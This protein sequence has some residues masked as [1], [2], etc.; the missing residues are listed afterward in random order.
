MGGKGRTKSFEEH[1]FNLPPSMK[2]NLTCLRTRSIILLVWGSNLIDW[3]NLITRY[4]ME[5]WKWSLMYLGS[6]LALHGGIGRERFEFC[7][8]LVG[9]AKCTS[10]LEED[11]SWLLP[12]MPYF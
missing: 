1:L 9:Y 11:G 8:G 2:S 12:C 4:V 7:C 5:G 6:Y 10:I 3:C